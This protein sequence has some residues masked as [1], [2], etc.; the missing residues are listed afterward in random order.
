MSGLG[1]Q[2]IIIRV[3]NHGVVNPV[4]RLK[5]VNLDVWFIV[6]FKHTLVTYGQRVLFA[7]GQDIRE[8]GDRVHRPYSHSNIN[9]SQI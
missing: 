8:P 7:A 3:A 2:G 6:K 9:R 5:P 4:S 1:Y